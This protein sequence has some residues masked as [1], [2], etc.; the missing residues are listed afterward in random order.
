MAVLILV[1]SNRGRYDATVRFPLVM[2]SVPGTFSRC[3]DVN[4][5][6]DN[7]DDGSVIKFLVAFKFPKSQANRQHG[8]DKEN[9]DHKL[10]K[11]REG[12]PLRVKPMLVQVEIIIQAEGGKYRGWG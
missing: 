12:L 5:K 1:L 11:C 3:R 4:W 9:G 6:Y 10:K 2:N 8:L 7:C